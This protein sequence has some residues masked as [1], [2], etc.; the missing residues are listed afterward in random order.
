M[1]IHACLESTLAPVDFAIVGRSVIYTLYALRTLTKI[2]DQPTHP[3]PLLLTHPFHYI[4]LQPRLLHP[5]NQPPH[6]LPEPLK[7]HLSV[8]QKNTHG[9]ARLVH[10]RYRCARRGRMVSSWRA[11]EVGPE[12]GRGC[13]WGL[14]GR[15]RWD[16]I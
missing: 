1:G 9:S 2:P 7:V 12:R 16:E 5:I 8:R 11:A 6:P 10:R 4:H 13:G 15:H 14:R 3:L